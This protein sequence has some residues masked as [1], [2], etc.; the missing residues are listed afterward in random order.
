MIV[1]LCYL[2]KMISFS[3][4][5]LVERADFATAPIGVLPPRNRQG[6]QAFLDLERSELPRRSRCAAGGLGASRDSVCGPDQI[7]FTTGEPPQQ[8]FVQEQPFLLPLP[9]EPFDLRVLAT[10]R[11]RTDS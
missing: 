5:D 4:T 3:P 7:V 11:V 1:T 2:Q 10:R 9:R 8:R 6:E